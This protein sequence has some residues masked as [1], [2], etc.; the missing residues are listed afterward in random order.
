MYI[1]II[2]DCYLLYIRHQMIREL[3]ICTV[4]Q[5][6]KKKKFF[7]ITIYTPY[8]K[9]IRQLLFKLQQ[10]YAALLGATGQWA[11]W[12]VQ[13]QLEAHCCSHTVSPSPHQLPRTLQHLKFRSCR[14]WGVSCERNMTF[15][16]PFTYP[17]P[18]YLLFSYNGSLFEYRITTTFFILLLLN[19]FS[20]TH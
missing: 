3:L 19:K 8:T 17:V 16:N 4:H 11:Q 10:S 2:S 12:P 14:L 15:S 7:G 13:I 1:W 5:K 9:E 20:C 18:V 6:R